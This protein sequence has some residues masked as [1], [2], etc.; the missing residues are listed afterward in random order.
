SYPATGFALGVDRLLLS[1]AQKE[2]KSEL[3]L[4]A[5][6][7]PGLVL[8]KAQTLRAEGK[9]VIAELRRIT[10]QEAKLLSREKEAQLVWLGG[11]TYYGD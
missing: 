4:V 6:E 7:E 9:K 11:V 8:K 1:L 2:K 10:E 5:G 3:F